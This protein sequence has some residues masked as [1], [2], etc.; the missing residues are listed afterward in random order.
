MP[1]IREILPIAFFTYVFQRSV[2]FSAPEISQ[3]HR[4]KIAYL[5]WNGAQNFR[6][7]NCIPTVGVEYYVKFPL[8][9]LLLILVLPLPES[10]TIMIFIFISSSFM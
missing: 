4:V 9:N 5:L 2:L 8:K 1:L 6:F 3:Q 10:P 7:A